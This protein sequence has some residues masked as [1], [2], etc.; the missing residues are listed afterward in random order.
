[1]KEKLTKS[2][3]RVRKYGEVYTPMWVVNKMLD[4]LEEENL[5]AFTDIDKTFL[6][7][8][9]GNGQ[10][11]EGIFKRK[12]RF[13][14]KYQDGLRALKSITAIDILEDNCKESRERLYNIYCSSYADG[15]DE[16]KETLNN[17]IICGDSLKIM[18]KWYKENLKEETNKE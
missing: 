3:E 4:M 5:D 7:P 17:N 10:F 6:E 9:C 12:L 11:L 15:R 8:S 1:M 16:A 14:N 18:D 2:A 13:C